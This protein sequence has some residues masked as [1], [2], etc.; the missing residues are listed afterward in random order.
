MEEY[1]DEIEDWVLEELRKIGCN[2]AKSVLRIPREDLEK[3]TDLELSTIDNVLEVLATEFDEDELSELGYISHNPR[4]Q[5]MPSHSDYESQ[6][7]QE[8]EQKPLPGEE[9]EE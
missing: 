6:A 2:T 8:E 1:A 7:P 4:T 3:R 9:E 5:S